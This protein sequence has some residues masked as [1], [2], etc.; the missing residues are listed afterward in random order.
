MS[1]PNLALAG[2]AEQW[3]NSS[4]LSGRSVLYVYPMT[5][6]PGV[7]LPEGW[8]AIPGAR[9]CTPEACG[10]RDHLGELR[11]AGIHNVLGISSQSTAEQRESRTRLQLP[12][13][14][15]SDANFAWADAL[16]FPTFHVDA[17]RFHRRLTLIAY[18]G[19]IEYVFYPVFP[20]DTHAAEVVAWL[21]SNSA[22]L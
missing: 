4:T 19:M 2:T 15:L 21:Q 16:A 11:D 22:N 12:F 13:E 3:V 18:D 10:F 5:G 14:L 8:D 17:R 6:R 1:L 20:P 7:A 9:G